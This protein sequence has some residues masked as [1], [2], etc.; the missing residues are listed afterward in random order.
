MNLYSLF[1]CRESHVQQSLYLL[2]IAEKAVK[3]HLLTKSDQ[4]P[5]NVIVLYAADEIKIEYKIERVVLQVSQER[6]DGLAL[7]AAQV[8]P[9]VSELSEKPVKA[10]RSMRN[11]K[12]E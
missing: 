5:D 1:S 2:I 11:G 12:A 6:R 3:P 9:A 7:Y 8:Q 10:S 4:Q